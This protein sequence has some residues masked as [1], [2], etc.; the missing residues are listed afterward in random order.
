M[1][2]AN[3]NTSVI[4]E[5]IKNIYWDGSNFWYRN[6]CGWCIAGLSE[7]R[8]RLKFNHKLT[9]PQIKEALVQLHEENR[10][11]AAGPFVFRPEG[12]LEIEGRRVLNTAVNCAVKPVAEGEKQYWGPDGNFPYLSRLVDSLLGWHTQRESF[13]SWWKT[14]YT[15]ALTNTPARGENILILGGVGVGKTL[16]AR[17]IGESVGGSVDV[18]GTR[19]EFFSDTLSI[20][21]WRIEDAPFNS[22][23]AIDWAGVLARKSPQTHRYHRKYVHPIMVEWAGRV[24]ITSSD[25]AISARILGPCENVFRCLPGT[26]PTLRAAISET[27]NQELPYFLRWLLTNF[28]NESNTKS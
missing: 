28:K 9:G 16:L 19:I 21:L 1:G 22:R 7:I 4:A 12:I 14:F 17:T 6:D 20:P 8:S 25:D 11:E 10:I 13:L 27:I 23:T 15:S 26:P 5:A 24:V 2:K 3:S 18:S